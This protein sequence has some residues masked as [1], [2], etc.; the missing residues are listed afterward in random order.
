MKL[1]IIRAKICTWSQLHRCYHVYCQC[2]VKMRMGSFIHVNSLYQLLQTVQVLTHCVQYLTQIQSLVP[3]Y[4]C[5]LLSAGC[6][7]TGAGSVVECPQLGALFW[8]R[9]LSFLCF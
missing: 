1:Y 2:Q 9:Q 8:G 4:H 6:V 7:Q 5:L 3:T